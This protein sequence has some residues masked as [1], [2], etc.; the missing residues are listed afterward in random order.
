MEKQT[1]VVEYSYEETLRDI[2]RSFGFVPGFFKGIPRD[3]LTKDWALMKKYQLGKS[4][5]PAKYRE[6]IGLAVAANI[7]CP[8]CQLMHKAMSK[9]YGATDEELAETAFL[10]SM[11]ARWSAM[12]HA[13]HYDYQRFR[14]EV[15]QVGRYAQKHMM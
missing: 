1:V 4:E 5:I 9:F 10:A 8:Y 3:V 6:L 11:T 14:K 2:E 12:L 7:K 13:Q 15:E